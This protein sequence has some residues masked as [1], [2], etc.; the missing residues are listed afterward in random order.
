MAA[1]FATFEIPPPPPREHDKRHK[2]R[3]GDESRARKKERREIEAARRASF[4]D[5]EA[6]RIRA[7]D[8]TLGASS[9]RYVE[10]AGGTIDSVVADEDT[11]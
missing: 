7:V 4:V 3:D 11:I 1:L 10:T 6:R 5:E 9:S 8:S 2:V